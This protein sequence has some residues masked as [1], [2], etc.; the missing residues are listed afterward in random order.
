MEQVSFMRLTYIKL[1]E[2]VQEKLD[3]I[4]DINEVAPGLFLADYEQ[5]KI[6]NQSYA[7]KI[8]EKD[9][10]LT[11]LRTKC[12]STTQVGVSKIILLSWK[13]RK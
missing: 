3:A 9:E 6:I 7:D 4:N 1:K 13:S 8:E 10:E 12:S 5:L 2:M 11:R